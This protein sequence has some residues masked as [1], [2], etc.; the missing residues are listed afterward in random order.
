[1]QVGGTDSSGQPQRLAVAPKRGRAIVFF[2]SDGEGVP[3]DRTL[4]AGEPTDDVKWVAQ[5]WL[6]ERPYAPNVPEGSSHEE[7]E[8][9][10][11][12]Y[13]KEHG[14]ILPEVCFS[15]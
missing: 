15:R 3:D 2:P 5:L 1:M 14:V 9:V 8:P 13:A 10:I 7:A 11:A 12:A 4:H 6:H